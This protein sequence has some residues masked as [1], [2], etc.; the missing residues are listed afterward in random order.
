MSI[1]DD[2]YGVDNLIEGFKDI[3]TPEDLQNTIQNGKDIF[4]KY[5][6]DIKN[7]PAELERWQNVA[8]VLGILSE[9]TD[10]V[11]D[12]KDILF[13]QAVDM[14]KGTFLEGKLGLDNLLSTKESLLGLNASKMSIGGVMIDY[15]YNPNP[16]Y[17]TNTVSQPI[18]SSS[19]IDNL[20]EHAENNNPTL[21][22]R[23]FLKGEDRQTRFDEIN[24]LRETK[25]IVQV[26]TNQVYDR[27]IITRLKPRYNNTINGL[28]FQIELENVFIAQ[29]QRT[30]S[31]RADNKNIK[32]G[33]LAK[34]APKTNAFEVI[35]DNPRL[36]EITRMPIPKE[37]KPF[38]T[39]QDFV[40]DPIQNN[41]GFQSPLNYN[42]YSDYKKE[43]LEKTYIG[44]AK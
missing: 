14:S 10:F 3:R 23:V 39:M 35:K 40:K 15:V 43:F 32:G 44:V 18:I 25:Q 37:Q 42:S 41:I 24:Q 26:V 34:S 29:L 20:S 27:M 19:N 6:T 30:A 9:N 11:N 21:T 8:K 1:L 12:A 38:P 31:K 13:K 17:E 16:E 5:I 7:V 28:E 2:I 36:A 33:N 4:D 22:M